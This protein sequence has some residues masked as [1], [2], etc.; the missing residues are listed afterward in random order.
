MEEI[1]VDAA[2]EKVAIVPIDHHS[3][4]KANEKKAE[5]AEQ[6]PNFN[7]RLIAIEEEED[8][9]QSDDHSGNLNLN[10]GVLVLDENIIIKP[11]IDSEDNTPVV[12]QHK[13]F[14]HCM[15]SN[16]KDNCQDV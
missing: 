5:I 1:D 14:S 11:T 4:G 12:G 2:L 10:D 8:K 9:E 15:E 13:D 16:K 3:Y 6:Q 7:R